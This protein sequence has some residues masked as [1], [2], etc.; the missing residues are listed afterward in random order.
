MTINNF[1]HRP[2][3]AACNLILNC[4]LLASFQ[5]AVQ[6]GQSVE[7]FWNP[8]LQTQVAGYKIYFGT[9]SQQYTNVVSVGNCTNTILTGLAPGTTYYYAATT[10]DTAGNESAFS[11]EASY[12][13]PPPAATL[14]SAVRAGGS[15]SFTVTGNPGQECVVQTSTNLLDWIAL[16]TNA[17]P[18][19]FMDTQAAQFNQRFYR[20]VSQ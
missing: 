16:Q 2:R 15:F 12:T 20:T 4:A 17:A 10:I 1:S 9:V 3:K 11:N 5:L 13:V 18:F 19:V 8:T 7:L 14:T 6:A